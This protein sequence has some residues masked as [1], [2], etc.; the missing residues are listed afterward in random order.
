MNSLA[1]TKSFSSALSLS[2][3][4]LLVPFHQFFPLYTNI[5]LSPISITLFMSWVM[6]IVVI[7]Y[8]TVISRISSSMTIEVLGSRPELGSSQNK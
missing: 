1:K 5:M 4:S 3:T 2:S 8:S 7:L 6:M